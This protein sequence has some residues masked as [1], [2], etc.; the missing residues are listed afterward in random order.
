MSRLNQAVLPIPLRKGLQIA[1]SLLHV[2]ELTSNIATE[3]DKLKN[4]DR[5]AKHDSIGCCDVS[6]NTLHLHDNA[7]CVCKEDKISD[8]HV[9]AL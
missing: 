5:D 6:K 9:H 2:Q 3:A 1:C 7:H 8:A 4:N